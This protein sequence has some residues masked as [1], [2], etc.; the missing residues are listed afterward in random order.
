VS[1]DEQQI[2]DLTAKWMAATRAGDIETV[3]TLMTDDVVFLV[4]GQQPFGKGVFAAA[5]RAPT[6]GAPMPK[7]DGTSE[8]QEVHVE[9][10][11]AY[12]WTKLA[13][14]VTPPNG[15]KV[16]KRAGYTLTV[17]RKTDGKWQ[18]ARDANL[19]VSQ[20]S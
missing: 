2:R 18:I 13:V 15:G 6:P 9:G 8:I 3:L 10:N 5:S 16:V 14:D 19:L 11:L 12:M 7:F 20:S 4:P 17:L 1:S